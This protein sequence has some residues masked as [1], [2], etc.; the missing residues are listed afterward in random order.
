MSENRLIPMASERQYQYFRSM[1]TKA[2]EVA[3]IVAMN[4]DIALRDA[5]APSVAGFDIIALQDECGVGS[6][7]PMPMEELSCGM[8]GS[9]GRGQAYRRAAARAM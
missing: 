6:V 7:V 2:I 4:D 8:P 1:R 3:L 9:E 5:M